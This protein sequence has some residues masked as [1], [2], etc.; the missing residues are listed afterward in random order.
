MRRAS[1][2]CIVAT[3]AIVKP[4][5]LAHALGHGPGCRSSTGYDIK[6]HFSKLFGPANK[7]IQLLTNI[8]CQ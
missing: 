4:L 5:G 3:L 6:W 8:A 1:F 7:S 2:Q